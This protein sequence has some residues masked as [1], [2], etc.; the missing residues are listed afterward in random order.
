M[1]KIFHHVLQN[2]SVSEAELALDQEWERV[3]PDEKG[4][5]SGSPQG[6]QPILDS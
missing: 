1:K 5:D 6:I 3:I 2:P 4:E